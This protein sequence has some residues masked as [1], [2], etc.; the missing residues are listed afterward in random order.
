MSG[1]MKSLHYLLL[2]VMIGSSL[3]AC[4]APA[5]PLSNPTLAATPALNPSLPAEPAATKVPADNPSQPEATKPA[6][7]LAPLAVN[8]TWHMHQPFYY[9]D[10]NG[11]YSRPWVRVHATKD[12]LDMAELIAR[13]PG[14]KATINK[15]GRAHV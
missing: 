6:S 1:K 12:Y 4:A 3:A 11:V 15:I 8:L 9:K 2:L 13:Y 10:E 7:G 5:K 14:M